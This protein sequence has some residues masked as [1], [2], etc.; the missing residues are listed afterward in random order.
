MSH[1][2]WSSSKFKIYQQKCNYFMFCNVFSFYWLS[3]TRTNK[4]SKTYKSYIQILI[5]WK[6]LQFQSRFHL[7][8]V[9][10]FDVLTTYLIPPL[11]RSIYAIFGISQSTIL[12]TSLTIKL[13]HSQLVHSYLNILF[14]LLRA[15]SPSKLRPLHLSQ[16][17]FE[18]HSIIHT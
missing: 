3:T 1:Y 6:E 5:R 2:L 18:L 14:A 9:L 8:L 13:F 10:L 4:Q 7:S 12:Y 17:C 11:R 15:N 16:R